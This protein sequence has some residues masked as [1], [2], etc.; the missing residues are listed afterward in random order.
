MERNAMSSP[1]RFWGQQKPRP[2]TPILAQ[3]PEPVASGDAAMMRIYD[4]IDSWGG[5][6]GVSAKEFVEALDALPANT[7]SIDL[8]LNSPGGDVFEGIAILNALR[9]H[10]AEVTITVEGLAASAASFIAAGVPNTVMAPGAQMMI[11]DAWGIVMGNAADMTAMAGTLDSISNNIASIYAN[12]AGGTTAS[13]RAAMQAETWYSAEEAVAAGLAQSV[14]DLNVE[15]K[16]S[17]DLSVFTYA[18]RDKAPA[19]SASR[20]RD[21]PL[22][23]HAETVLTDLDGL[24]NRLEKVIAFRVE[25]GKSRLSEDSVELLDRLDAL[26]KRFT[27]LRD[28][29]I[30]N[31]N[32]DEIAREFVRFVELS[33]G[34]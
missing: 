14:A 12:A 26:A 1:F 25:K 27:A 5:P 30:D 31:V 24:Y 19:P 9:A 2:R 7:T 28:I 15:A 11:H 16:D 20:E 33:Q 3:A 4:P 21:V 17:F 6:W 10:D 22:L 29:P 23:D 8:R 13:W 18:G 34:V 32:D